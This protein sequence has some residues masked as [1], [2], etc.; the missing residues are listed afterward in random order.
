MGFHL[1]GY[2]FLC[3]QGFG[4][5]GQNKFWTNILSIG[6][7]SVIGARGRPPR[8]RTPPHMTSE[9]MLSAFIRVW[10]LRIYPRVGAPRVGGSARV[11]SCCDVML[12]VCSASNRYHLTPRKTTHAVTFTLIRQCPMSNL[13]NFVLLILHTLYEVLGSSTDLL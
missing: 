11:T 12:L 5:Y 9:V 10:G 8:A 3:D 2:T 7:Y 4:S 6:G 13:L 1:R